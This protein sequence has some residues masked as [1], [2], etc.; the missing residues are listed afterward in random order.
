MK[1]QAKILSQILRHLLTGGLFLLVVTGCTM[2][3]EY[4]RPTMPVADNMSGFKD[5]PGEPSGKKQKIAKVSELGWRNVFVDP[6][7]QQLIETALSNNRDLRETVLNVESYQAQYRIQRSALL[8][9]IA[10]DGY[11]V[12]QRTLGGSGH[13]TSETYSLKVGTTAYELDL[14]GRVRSLKDQALEQY[15]AMQETRK[16][17]T[18][19]LVA[20]VA[21][22]Y[23]TWRTDRELLQ[24]SEDTRKIEEESYSLIQQRTTAGIAN[25]LDLAQ[26]RTSLE[27]VKANLALYRRQVAQDLHYLTL[28]TGTSLPD[29]SLNEKISLVDLVPLSGI[30]STLSSTLLLERPDIMAAE[31]QLIGVNANI[32][33]ARA[34]FFPTVSLT[35]NA[36]VISS[37]LSDLFDGG[38][39]S[40]LFSPTISLPIFTAGR[41]K[42]ELDVAKIRKEIYVAR[43]EKVIQTAFQEVTDSLVA[44]E[45]YTDQVRAQQANLKANE[46]Y[47]TL[48]RERYRQGVDS[49]L[50]LLDA[51]R[52]LY[53]SRQNYLTLNLAQLANEVNLYK[54]LGG[55]WK[56]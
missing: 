10:G 13:V 31:H 4:L 25:E 49:F 19:S 34:A 2:V 37:D 6:L 16:S 44:R 42:A 24:I 50:V 11:G 26:A 43:Y 3:P 48:A 47:F 30:P 54:V 23:L 21:Q 15:L 22:S 36:G 52:S 38:S 35:A 7:L 1:S 20:E 55:G 39:G 17:A 5:R 12:K 46:D 51:Q 33:A 18:I 45:T 8:P 41:L 14:Y 28:L 9:T 53:T 29:M 56:E 32:G 40:W 27:T